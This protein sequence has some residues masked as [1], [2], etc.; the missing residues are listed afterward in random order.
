MAQPGSM[1]QGYFSFGPQSERHGK[2]LRQRH[3]RTSEAH[4]LLSGCGNAFRLA[5]TN[6]FPLVLCGKGKDLEH[7]I[8]YERAEKILVLSG[9]EQRHVQYQNVHIHFLGKQSP[10]SLYFFIVS[11]Q[12]VDAGDADEVA[13]SEPAEHGP[14]L[15]TVKVLAGLFIHIDVVFLYGMFFHGHDL[16]VF[17]LIRAGDAYVSVGLSRH[18][19]GS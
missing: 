17:V 10:L 3:G 18:G 16:T 19:S 8:G 13:R 1:G 9:V 6:V 7:K 2:L 11:S 4:A 12:P 15:R 14:I 5:L